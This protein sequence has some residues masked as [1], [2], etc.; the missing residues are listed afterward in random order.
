MIGQPAPLL[1]I[2]TF[3]GTPVVLAD[4]RGRGVVVNFWASW[5]EP[6][7]VEAGLLEAAWQANQAEVTFIGVNMQDTD[8]SARAF[9]AEFGLTYPNGPDTQSWGRQFGVTGLPA[10][11]F[12]D[13]QGVIRS[14]VLGP[15]TSAADLDRRLEAIRE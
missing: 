9:V 3:D 13:P 12:I 11:F 6:C 4:L 10:T 7:R 14:A 1:A 5:C 8:K 15:I 2:T